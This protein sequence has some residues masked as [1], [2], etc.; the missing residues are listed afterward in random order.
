MMLIVFSGK[1]FSHKNYVYCDSPDVQHAAS[2]GRNYTANPCYK[3]LTVTVGGGYQLGRGAGGPG[4]VIILDITILKDTVNW[5][6]EKGK[7]D[8]E[9]VCE[10]NNKVQYTVNKSVDI[11]HLNI[12][13]FQLLQRDWNWEG[14]NLV[15]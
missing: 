8:A 13:G 10:A 3:P 1:N 12:Q 15:I 2:S 9:I 7:N 6:V 5:R 4:L 11:Q 14:L